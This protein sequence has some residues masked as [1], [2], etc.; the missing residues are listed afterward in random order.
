MDQL[1]IKLRAESPSKKIQQLCER[2]IQLIICKYIVLKHKTLE[3][4]KT[5]RLHCKCYECET[6]ST[7]SGKVLMDCFRHR[8]PRGYP[9]K[10]TARSRRRSVYFLNLAVY[11]TLQFTLR[12]CA[13]QS[14]HCLQN[15]PEMPNLVSAYHD[16]LPVRKNTREV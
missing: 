1:Q 12:T 8:H 14:D 11:R 16:V 13:V 4:L 6:L 3:P 9:V 5:G 2:V 15:R 7:T 10:I